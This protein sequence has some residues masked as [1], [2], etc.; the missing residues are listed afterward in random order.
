M[1]DDPYMRPNEIRAHLLMLAEERRAAEVRGLRADG[2]YM[3]D[4]EQ[5]IAAYR[6][7]L[8][9]ASVTEIAVQRGVLFG[10]DQG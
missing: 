7:A 9:G 1:S 10:R 6:H 4:L 5:E 2:A 3:T 8:V